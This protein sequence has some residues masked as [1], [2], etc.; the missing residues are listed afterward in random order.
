MSALTIIVGGNNM[1]QC[2]SPGF[3]RVAGNLTPPIDR[4]REEFHDWLNQRYEFL[5]KTL[6]EMPK[7]KV[8][9]RQRILAK[10]E[11][12]IAMGYEPPIFKSG[13]YTV[14]HSQSVG[15]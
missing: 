3:T 13:V 15:V 11:F 2:T 12:I 7:W 6:E 10:I 8:F 4:S 9:A 5:C 14:Q 1:E